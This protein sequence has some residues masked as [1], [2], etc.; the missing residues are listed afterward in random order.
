MGF[1]KFRQ[2]G[3]KGKWR[4]LK[5]H[6]FVESPLWMAYYSDLIFASPIFCVILTKYNILREEICT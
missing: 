5:I 6:V 1:L 3:T 4:G 2:Y